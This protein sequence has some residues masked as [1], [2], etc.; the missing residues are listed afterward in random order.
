M[1]FKT[2]MKVDGMDEVR[3]TSCDFGLSQSV[4]YVTGKPTSTVM[5]GQINVAFESTKSTQPYELMIN[6]N[7]VVKGEIQFFSDEEESP[8]RVLKFEEAFITGYSES[9]NAYENKPM[10]TSMIISSR[11]MGFGGVTHENKW[12]KGANT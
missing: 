6:P 3:L 11:K 1:A 2:T 10:E 7:K 5:G 12:A 8:M 9:I 4:D